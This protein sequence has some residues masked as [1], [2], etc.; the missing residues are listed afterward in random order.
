MRACGAEQITYGCVVRAKKTS[1]KRGADSLLFGCCLARAT[2]L[3]FMYV[4]A[5][6]Q[7][8]KTKNISCALRRPSSRRRYRNPPKGLLF[9]R[10][11]VKAAVPSSSSSVQ[12]LS[13]STTQ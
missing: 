8:E 13:I 2:K 9:I 4:H 12:H 11:P 5:G 1:A 7:T 6:Y 3:P 10:R